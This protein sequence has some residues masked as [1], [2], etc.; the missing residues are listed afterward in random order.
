MRNLSIAA[1]IGWRFP[2]ENAA[3]CTVPLECRI[4]NAVRAFAQQK[5]RRQGGWL[6]AANGLDYDLSALCLKSLRP[7]RPELRTGLA[8]F[9]G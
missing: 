9:G 3:R 6:P 2:E 5:E 1:W 7:A 8:G 4:K